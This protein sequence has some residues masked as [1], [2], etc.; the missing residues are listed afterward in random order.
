MA[1]ES[2]Y[3]LLS[4]YRKRENYDVVFRSALEDLA[5]TVELHW[6]KSCV[7]FGTGSGER[8]IELVQRLLPNLRAFH[9]VEPDAESVRALRVNARL[10]G[11]ETSV[12]ETSLESW[13]GVESPVDAVLFISMLP[14][15]HTTDRKALFQK[16]MTRYLNPGGIVIIFDNVCT[17]PSGFML[18]MERL[19]SPRVDCDVL[20]K[21]VLNAGFRIVLS[22][23]LRVSRDLSNPSDNIVKFMRLLA[24]RKV[25]E[26]EVRAAIDDI[27]GQ[28]N[29]D[30]CVK[31]LSIFA[32]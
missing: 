28:P 25:S 20:E 31:R 9:A 13:S 24:D 5:K 15:V 11:V 2:Y 17:V 10:P 22:R 29:M 12:V 7:A 16:L 26:Q 19:G 18:L 21:E 30:F 27:Y 6:V 8:E 32:K 4:E 23:D 3:R 1:D 14:H